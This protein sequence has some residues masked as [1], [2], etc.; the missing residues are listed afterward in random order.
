MSHVRWGIYMFASGTSPL[1]D[2]LN[3]G[4]LG[5]GGIERSGWGWKCVGCGE[6]TPAAPG[7]S[8]SPAP[9][10][11]PAFEREHAR[12]AAFVGHASYCFIRSGHPCSCGAD[13][14]RARPVERS[15]A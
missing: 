12:C 13:D 14:H 6:A 8:G 1:A 3:N 7:L 5:G 4:F 15:A 9:P 2:V 10:T 11:P